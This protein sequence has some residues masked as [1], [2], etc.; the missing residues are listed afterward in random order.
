MSCK[1]PSN[2]DSPSWRYDGKWKSGQKCEIYCHKQQEWVE[3]YIMNIFKDFKGEWIKI[4]YGDE[5]KEIRPDS[6]DIRELTKN[7]PTDV[8]NRWKVGALCEVYIRERGTWM[9]AEVISLLND[10]LGRRLRVRFGG[11]RVR[12]ISA[13]NIAHDLR[14]RGTSHLAV[15]LDD[16]QQLKAA[17]SGQS[18]IGTIVKRIFANSGQFVFDD[19]ANSLVSTSHSNIILLLPDHLQTC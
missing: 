12:D 17:T 15:T 4:E 11:Q 5:R 2:L 8:Y 10:A 19:S 1:H 16:F 7:R 14:S 13:K 18:T 9:E 6:P 3:G